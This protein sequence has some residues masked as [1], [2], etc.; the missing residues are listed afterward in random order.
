MGYDYAELIENYNNYKWA[1]AR[2][3]DNEEEANKEIEYIA[4]RLKEK[5]RS[6]ITI[7]SDEIAVLFNYEVFPYETQDGEYFDHGYIWRDYVFEIEDNE[8]YM[9]TFAYHDDRGIAD[10]EAQ[11]AIKCEHKPVTKFIWVPVE[12]DNE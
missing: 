8:N 1:S 6:G 7:T 5:F 11:V 2:F 3:H 4:S 12:E 9:M 10:N